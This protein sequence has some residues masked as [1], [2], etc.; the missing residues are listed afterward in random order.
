LPDI[1]PG[2]LQTHD[3]GTVKPPYVVS[4]SQAN[5]EHAYSQFYLQRQCAEFGKLGLMGVTVLYAAG[6]TGTSSAVTG[7]CLDKNGSYCRC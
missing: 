1:R 6:N 2:G 4:N 5:Q 3:C 7:Y